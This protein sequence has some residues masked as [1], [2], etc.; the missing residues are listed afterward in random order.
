MNLKI[1]LSASEAKIIDNH[2]YRSIKFLEIFLD[3]TGGNVKDNW[4]GWEKIWKDEPVQEVKDYLF[5]TFFGLKCMFEINKDKDGF[6]NINEEIKQGFYAWID[7]A[8]EKIDLSKYRTVLSILHEIL[9]GRGDEWAEELMKKSKKEVGSWSEERLKYE[10]E[11]TSSAINEN[12][13]K[14]KEQN[15]SLEG[16]NWNEITLQ[17]RF[18]GNSQRGKE[19][20][21]I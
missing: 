19:K 2:F 20:F 6:N 1:V 7:D 15:E 10:R 16:K 14:I 17:N 11:R 9:E 3:R 8:S 4:E 18:K 12:L 5:S 21:Y 13:E